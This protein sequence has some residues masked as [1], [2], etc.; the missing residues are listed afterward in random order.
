MKKSFALITFA[1]AIIFCMIGVSAAET[2]Y[3]D[4]TGATAG[5]YTDISSAFAALPNG[6]TIIVSGDTQ[7]GT[8]S[9]GITL[10]AVGGKVTFTSENGAKL[11]LA[12]TFTVNSEI[13]FT[14]INIHSVATNL[15][16]I[17]ANGNKIT[18]YTFE[19]V[20]MEVNMQT[21]YT[22]AFF[23]SDQKTSASINSEW[24]DNNE[25]TF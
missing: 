19:D 4:G 25:Q 3:L 6:G 24:K 12:R 18:S 10:N 23:H 20:E 8:S 22:G 11:I 14:N 1:L 5:A 16:N 15:A 13:E 21:I 2:V 17:Y 9:K 7:I